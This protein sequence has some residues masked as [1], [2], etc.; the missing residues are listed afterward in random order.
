MNFWMWVYV[1]KGPRASSES[2][3]SY[4]MS[5]FFMRASVLG[6]S[7][8]VALVSNRAAFLLRGKEKREVP[9]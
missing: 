2:S 8:D 4:T 9:L 1:G 6:N 5:T 7:K 3:M